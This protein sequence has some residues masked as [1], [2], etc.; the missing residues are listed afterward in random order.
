MEDSHVTDCGVVH[1]VGQVDLSVIGDGAVVLDV[2]EGRKAFAL[3][4]IHV[5]QGSVEDGIAR[6]PLR[7]IVDVRPP[8]ELDVR[9]SRASVSRLRVTRIRPAGIEPVGQCPDRIEDH[10]HK[11]PDEVTLG[12]HRQGAVRS[13]HVE[14]YTRDAG[15]EVD[16]I[17]P[18]RAPVGRAAEV[19]RVGISGVEVDE[20]PVDVVRG[21]LRCD[22]LLEEELV[23]R[24]GLVGDLVRG[25]KGLEAAEGIQDRVVHAAIDIFD[26]PLLVAEESQ[27]AKGEPADAMAPVL[28]GLFSEAE[29]T[30]DIPARPVVPG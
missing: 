3:D 18:C 6:M 24:Q 8:E 15:V 28:V 5:I 14:S 1:G 7:I 23:V 27:F 20:A 26:V 13:P 2:V 17:G 21:P 22:R 29:G 16:I 25:P 30:D 11:G 4:P 9:P 19:G 12:I 10:G